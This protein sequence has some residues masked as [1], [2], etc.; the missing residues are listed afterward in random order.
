MAAREEALKEKEAKE[1]AEAKAKASPSVSVLGPKMA[2]IEAEMA[3]D[4]AQ[5][6]RALEVELTKAGRIDDAIAV[7]EYRASL[8]FDAQGSTVE[9]EEGGVA[10]EAKAAAGG[11]GENPF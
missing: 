1:K 8:A 4:F 11:D 7:K 2:K 6:L 9:I 10:P 3:G 5:S